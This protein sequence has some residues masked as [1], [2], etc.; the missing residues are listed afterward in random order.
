[1]EV[2]QKKH[3]HWLDL[4]RFLA[5]LAVVFVH[6]RGEV[7]ETYSLLE[8]SSQNTFTYILYAILSQGFTGVI[9]FFVLSGFLVGGRTCEKIYNKTADAKQYA[10]DRIVRIGLPLMGSILLIIIVDFVLGKSSDFVMLAGNVFALQGIF[11]RDAGGVFWT[12]SYEMWFYCLIFALILLCNNK[13]ALLGGGVLLLSF[14]AFTALQTHYLLI[15]ICGI[16]SY[17][18]ART[19]QQKSNVVMIVSLIGFFISVLGKMLSVTSNSF[20]MSRFGFINGNVMTVLIGGFAALFIS[21]VVLRKP[22]AS[23]AVCIDKVGSK[24]AVFSYSLYLTHWQVLRVVNH[25][26]GRTSTID[27]TALF[28]YAV[29][30]LI[31]VVFAYLFYLLTEK[32]TAVVKRKAL[33]I[34]GK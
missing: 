16:F 9:V 30:I 23:L 22:K 26:I 8:P 31:C 17:Y 2:S 4:L 14:A 12:L 20:D 27:A 15:L 1:M 21:D 19:R 13:K 32:H 29:T 25:F 28:K 33:K 10:V 11:V 3:Y 18:L 34:I 5:A 24:L 7:W 6:A